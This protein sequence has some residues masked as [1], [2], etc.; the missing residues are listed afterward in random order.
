MLKMESTY[1]EIELIRS[2]SESPKRRDDLLDHITENVFPLLDFNGWVSDI[3]LQVPR[4]RAITFGAVAEALGSGNAARAVGSWAA[5]EHSCSHRLIYSSGRVPHKSADKLSSEIELEKKGEDLHVPDNRIIREAAV[6]NP[7][8]ES[9]RELQRIT[10]PFLSMKVGHFDKL[11][12]IDISSKDQAHVCAVCVMEKNGRPIGDLCFWGK[13]GIPYVSGFL[14]FREAPIILP[15]LKKSRDEGL[16]DDRT[17]LVI[18]G[19]GYLHPRRMGIACQVGAVSGMMT[20]GIAKKLMTGTIGSWKR[21]G[22]SEELA[23]IWDDSDMLGYA[24]RHGGGSP[25]YISRGNRTRLEDVVKIIVELKNGRLPEPVRVAHIQANKCRR[26]ETPSG[27][28]QVLP[29]SLH[30][31]I[32]G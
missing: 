26:S 18:D 11:A 22:P 12:G 16:V 13:I 2:V 9:L 10:D 5:Q 31:R 19:N 7:P 21:I 23:E 6:D 15:A 32:D 29:L 20:C 14:F 3:M 24:S 8:F 17:L 27:D 4:G 28:L 30:E 25:I 1:G